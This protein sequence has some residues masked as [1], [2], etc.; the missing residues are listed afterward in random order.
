MAFLSG[1]NGAISVAGVSKPLTSWS[2]DV[3]TENIDVTNFS[4]SG[5]QELLSGILSV[6]ISAEGPYNG[7]SGVTQGTAATFILATGT[8]GAFSGPSFEVNA[9]ITSVKVNT[10]VKDVAKISYTASSTGTPV[11]I[12]P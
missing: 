4:S 1:K 12:S 9:V 5:W 7:S 11:S 6:D 2:I 8:T 10:S 3:K